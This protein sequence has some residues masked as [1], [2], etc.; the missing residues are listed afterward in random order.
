[1]LLMDRDL[2]ERQASGKI[3]KVT[4]VTVPEDHSALPFSRIRGSLF[5]W[6]MPTLG[7]DILSYTIVSSSLA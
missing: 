6:K 5:A 7:H 1:M 3:N 2:P 4:S